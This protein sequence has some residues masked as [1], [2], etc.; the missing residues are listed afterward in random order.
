[1]KDTQLTKSLSDLQSTNQAFRDFR[2]QLKNKNF[3]EDSGA[4]QLQNEYQSL[5]QVDNQ[6]DLTRREQDAQILKNF[7]VSR[8]LHKTKSMSSIPEQTS[9]ARPG[10]RVSVKTALLNDAEAK[11]SYQ[12]SP[13]LK[14]LVQES[15]HSS[16]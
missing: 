12:P 10:N 13:N 14:K 1:M 4:F 16:A 6:R 9:K 2:S 5:I 3:E 11:D 8:H 7:V 15:I